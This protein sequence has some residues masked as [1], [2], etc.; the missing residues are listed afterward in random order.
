[1]VSG[2]YC[3]GWGFDHALEKMKEAVA[4]ETALEALRGEHDAPPKVE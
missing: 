4:K 2:A 3:F 1:M